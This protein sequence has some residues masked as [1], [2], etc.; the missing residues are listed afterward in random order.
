MDLFLD[1]IDSGIESVSQNGSVVFIVN[2]N[3]HV[4]FSPQNQ[5][6]FKVNVSSEA[7]DLRSSDNS[8]LSS[9]INDSLNGNTSVREVTLDGKVYYM[10]GA[11]MSTVGWA[12]ISAI[13]KDLCILT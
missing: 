11:P 8:E 9:F 13:E 4:I 1:S 7:V 5:T 2:E 3:G 10:S 12:I 6:I